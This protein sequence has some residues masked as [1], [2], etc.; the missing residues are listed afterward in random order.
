MADS[1]RSFGLL[2]RDSHGC[3][4]YVNASGERSIG[5]VPVRAFPIVAPSHGVSLVDTHGHEV[6]WIDA[7][8]ALPT[9]ARSLIEAEL[10][11]RDF[12]PRITRLTHVSSFSTPSVWHVTTDRGDTEF[13]LKVEEDIRRL[14]G[15]ALLIS[16]SHGLQFK[17]Q[18][19]AQLD[20]HSRRLLERFL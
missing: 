18:D 1:N 19:V 5:V 20:R 12:M 15:G 10:A 13:T 11:V 4:V 7:L 6:V 16:S 14:E 8:H 17:V 9:S 3:L 2:E